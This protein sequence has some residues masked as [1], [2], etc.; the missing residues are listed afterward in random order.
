[1][2]DS[3]AGRH[4]LTQQ[5]CTASTLLLEPCNIASRTAKPSKACVRRSGGEL[6]SVIGSEVESKCELPYRICAVSQG[7]TRQRPIAHR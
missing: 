3:S 4:H 6:Y 7:R 1:M 5:A 2:F